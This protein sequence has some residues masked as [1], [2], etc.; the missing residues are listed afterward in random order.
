MALISCP[1]CGQSVSSTC[2]T[3]PH[4]GFD[5]TH[6]AS[7][8]DL[9]I[10]SKA[11]GKGEQRKI[12]VWSRNRKVRNTMATVVFIIGL[13]GAINSF[14]VVLAVA[15]AGDSQTA[16]ILSGIACMFASLLTSGI[17]GKAP[18]NKNNRQAKDII[19]YDTVA[20]VFRVYDINGNEYSMSRGE[21]KSKI[22]T[23]PL[24][25]AMHNYAV[26]SLVNQYKKVV[27]GYD[28]NAIDNKLD[29]FL[30]KLDKESNS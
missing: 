28:F 13:V 30:I 21:I 16:L 1:E 26:L 5:M 24:R 29:E 27:L 11:L 7:Q 12:T 4:C 3:C 6:E 14:I 23:T 8:K 17:I 19:Y 22:T 18:V 9:A 2:K 15:V 20:R 25:G 10:A